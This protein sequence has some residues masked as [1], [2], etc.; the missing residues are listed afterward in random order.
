MLQSY[1]H[2]FKEKVSFVEFSEILVPSFL[3]SESDYGSILCF[4]FILDLVDGLLI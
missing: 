2:T 1:L 4:L 3:F